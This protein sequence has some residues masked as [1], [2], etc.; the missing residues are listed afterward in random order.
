MRRAPHG[1]QQHVLAGVSLPAWLHS[2]DREVERAERAA[3]GLSSCL[4][5][6]GSYGIRGGVRDA[7]C[8][9]WLFKVHL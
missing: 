7:A 9:A 5:F 6:C 4:G 2:Q 8:L 1:A 3:A